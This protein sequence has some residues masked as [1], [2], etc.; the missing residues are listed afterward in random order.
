MWLALLYVL[1][2][3]VTILGIVI[4]MI[5]SLS[6][7]LRILVTIITPPLTMALPNTLRLAFPLNDTL[8]GMYFIFYNT[9][10]VNLMYCGEWQSSAADVPFLR[11]PI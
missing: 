2:F 9:S 7:A 5:G 6:E 8:V 11:H 10:F 3:F 4:P 1:S